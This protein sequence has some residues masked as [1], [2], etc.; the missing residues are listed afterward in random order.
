MSTI[1][2]GSTSVSVYFYITQDASAT[3]PGEPITGLLFSDIETGGS[4][5][6]AR[7]G[8][9]RADLTLITLASASATHADGG[10]IL[11]DDTNM[12]GVYRCDYPDAAFATGVDQVICSLVVAA[13]KNAVVAPLEINLDTIK[14]LT[15]TI[16]TKVTDLQGAGF[17][18]ATD[19]N[20]ALRARGDSA[21]TGGATT[22]DSGTAQAGSA[23]TITL[24]SGASAIDDTFNGQVVFINAG[25]GVGQSKAIAGVPG[26]YV[27]STKVATIIG[28]WATNPDATS[29]YEIFPDDIDEIVSAPT[30]AQNA[31]AVWDVN[32]TGHTGSGSFGEQCKN[33][34]DAIL[35]DTGST[36][37]SKVDTISTNVD[38]IL[39]DTAEIGV[40]GLGLSN[41]PW[42]S[43]VWDAEVQSEVADALA[44]YDGPTKAELD[45]LIGTPATDVS[46]DIAA[47]KSDSAAILVDTGT[48]LNTLINGI[49]GK[50]DTIDTVVDAIKVQTDKLVF[51][52]AN[53]LDVNA[54]LM[55][56]VIIIGAGTSGDKWRA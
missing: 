23:T 26:S 13:A 44:V 6:Y 24:R 18:T 4:A 45:T 56:S 33:D 8:A 31:D 17:V 1:I 43:S 49:N 14:T 29:V 51:T 35:V 46:A 39:V 47:V 32:T 10:F 55:N 12:P 21:W 37:N 3:S 50:V 53:R 25:T 54:R 15:T 7:Q 48:T 9:A 2:A 19:S 36:L 52:V 38:S 22:S 34:I 28:T 16:D 5:S 40:A 41:L 11:V 30:A 42:N 20:E 27:G